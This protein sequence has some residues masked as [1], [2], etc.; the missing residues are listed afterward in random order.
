MIL[1]MACVCLFG[2]IGRKYIRVVN[3]L[4]KKGGNKK[5]RSNEL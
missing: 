3:R 1:K 5:E 2:K 4:E